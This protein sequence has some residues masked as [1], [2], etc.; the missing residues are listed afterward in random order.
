M[1]TLIEDLLE[2]SRITRAP[3]QL[4]PV[5]LSAV[6]RAIVEELRRADPA[7]VVQVEISPGLTAR[8]DRRLLAI[9]LE[10]LLGNAW[11][12]TSKRAQAHIWFGREG[13]AFFVRDDGAGFDMAFA[14]KLFAPFQRLHHVNE[15]DGTGVGL[16][17]VQRIVAR[18]GG[19]ISARAVEG[20]GAT[21]L[22]TLGE[23][24]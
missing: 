9:A 6:A 10:N 19:R 23:A 12:F 17:T 24:A 18:H 21:F 4:D 1:A 13:D 2:L 5:D 20:E 7:R 22:F 16:A 14:G 11:K 8:G 3:L 15:F